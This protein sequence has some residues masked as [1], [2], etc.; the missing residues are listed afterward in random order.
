M[1]ELDECLLDIAWH[2]EMDLSL[3]VVPIEHDSDVS[4]ACPVFSDV[5][6]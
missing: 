5:A 3:V 6:V 4:F 2:G 1:A